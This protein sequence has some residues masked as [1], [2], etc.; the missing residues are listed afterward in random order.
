[1]RQQHQH[2]REN[3][4][5]LKV[6]NRPNTVKY[7]YVLALEA[8]KKAERDMLTSLSTSNDA[9]AAASATT[10]AVLAFAAAC[11]SAVQPF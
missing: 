7:D 1:M 8:K 5:T 3:S 9:F 2:A 10:A 4:P 11:I 6:S